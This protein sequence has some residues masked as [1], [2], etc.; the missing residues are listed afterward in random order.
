MYE[1][2]P[3]V[4]VREGLRNLVAWATERGYVGVA[5]SKRAAG[6]SFL[7]KQ[8]W[9]HPPGSVLFTWAEL[10]QGMD[11]ALAQTAVSVGNSVWRQAEGLPIGGPHSPASCS[12][13]LGADEAA[14]AGDP[15]ARASFGFDPGR[16]RLSEQ[17]ALARYVDDLIM[18]SRIWCATCLEDM[19]RVMYRKPVQFDRQASSPHG[20]PW[21]DMW[22]SF[23]GGSLRVHMDGQEQEWVQ[24]LA[25]RP[26]TKTRLKP[27]LGDEEGSLEAL[28]LHVSG[29]TARLRQAGLDDEALRRAVEREIL[30][31]AL[32]GYPRGMLLRVWSRSKQYPAAARH[33]RLVLRAWEGVLP[34]L[35]RLRPDWT[36]ETPAEPQFVAA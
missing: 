15:E 23:C 7:V 9:R 35:V 14:W 25:S 17:V 33:A 1:E 12:V 24:C 2:V 16:G 6:P 36:W 27:Y 11:L 8:R 32:H 34:R 4:R 18:V 22:I 5:V 28:R 13:V 19:L 10:C 21:L 29:R 31:L 30:V 20:Q 26:P 3:P